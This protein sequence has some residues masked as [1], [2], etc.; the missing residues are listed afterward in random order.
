MGRCL[1]STNSQKHIFTHLKDVFRVDVAPG[2][3]DLAKPSVIYVQSSTSRY[4]WWPSEEQVSDLQDRSEALQGRVT[5]LE[6]EVSELRQL[7]YQAAPTT[8]DLSDRQKEAAGL[9]LADNKY[10]TRQELADELD[11][12]DG[13]AGTLLSKLWDE[14]ELD[15]RVVNDKGKKAFCLKDSERQ[16][17]TG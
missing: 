17:I 16:R 9:W 13:Y 5:D 1:G 10:R 15:T 3:L 7:V 14:L 8:A 2:P 12:S 11:I 6:D 4:L